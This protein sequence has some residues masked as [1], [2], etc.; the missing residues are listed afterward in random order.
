VESRDGMH[1]GFD[2]LQGELALGARDRAGSQF[3]DH[4]LRVAQKVIALWVTL[5]WRSAH[6]DSGR[7]K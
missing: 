5:M 7:T 4:A 1:N 3:D 6:F 2:P